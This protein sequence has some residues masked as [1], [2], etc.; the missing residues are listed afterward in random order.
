MP[1][2]E[3]NNGGLIRCQSLTDKLQMTWVSRITDMDKGASGQ[4]Y[5][6]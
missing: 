3:H 4:V 6:P 2:Y 5:L 1:K